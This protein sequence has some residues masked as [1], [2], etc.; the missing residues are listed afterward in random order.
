MRAPGYAFCP[1]DGTPLTVRS[2][3]HGAELPTCSQCG[4]IDYGNPKPCVAVLIEREGRVLLARRGVEPKKDF[5]DIPGGFIE[6]GETAE[7]A[8]ARELL[9]ETALRVKIVR[10]LMSIS[11]RYGPR[12]VVTLNLCFTVETENWPPTAADDV[13]ELRLFSPDELP[14]ELAF[15]HQ[16]VVLN[17]WIEEC[18]NPPVH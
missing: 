9:E 1:Y 5:W 8:V 15:D 12:G 16:R 6:A 14:S 2:D 18:A 3:R 17:V 10:Y 4:F 13:T 7:E 11:D